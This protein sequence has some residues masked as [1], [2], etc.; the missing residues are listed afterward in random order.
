MDFVLNNGAPFGGKGEG[1]GT[2]LHVAAVAGKLQPGR[3]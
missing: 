1:G 3:C 2:P